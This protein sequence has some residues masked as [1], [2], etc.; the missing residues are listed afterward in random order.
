MILEDVDD[1][2]L[3]VCEYFFGVSKAT[4]DAMVLDRILVSKDPNE[5]YK[6]RVQLL[7]ETLQRLL[8]T[9]SAGDFRVNK[10]VA[11]RDKWKARQEEE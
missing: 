8:L 1:A 5:F 11:A 2:S 6:V 7:N 3:S 10:L 9:R 4:L